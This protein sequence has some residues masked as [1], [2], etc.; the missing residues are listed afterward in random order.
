MKTYIEIGSKIAKFKFVCLALLNCV[1][2][3]EIHSSAVPQLIFMHDGLLER[4]SSEISIGRMS[5]GWI[6]INVSLKECSRIP[7]P[8]HFLTVNFGDKSVRAEG[9]VKKHIFFRSK[10]SIWP[11]WLN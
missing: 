2:F 8:M 3:V 7:I 6:E 4:N 9:T 5:M 10:L 11:V 1:T